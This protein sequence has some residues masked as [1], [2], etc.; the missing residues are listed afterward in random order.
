MHVMLR[1]SLVA[2]MAAAVNCS[3][4]AVKST[5]DSMAV[6]RPA[7]AISCDDRL[8]TGARVGALRIGMPADSIHEHCPVVRD[9]VRPDN[10]GNPARVMSVAVATDTVMAEIVD[11]RVWRIQVAEPGLYTADSI[12]VGTP[13]AQLLDIPDARAIT[14]EGALFMVSPNR[15]GVSF[16][17][18]SGYP[19]ASRADPAALLRAL[20]PSTVVVRVLVFGCPQ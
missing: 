19:P 13:V 8:I 17:L 2:G 15:C 11:G 12:G 10:E 16:E 9:T 20:P 18:S 6:T 4:A 7:T 1:A 3:R 5:N 14:G